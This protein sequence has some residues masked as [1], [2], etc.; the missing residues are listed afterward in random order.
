MLE[1]ITA[2]LILFLLTKPI[3]LIPTI[4]VI[5]L[6]YYLKIRKYNKSSYYKITKVNYFGIKFDKGKYGEYLIY[7]Y[8]MGLEQ[9]GA[10]F[11]FN[12]YVPKND[13]EST[14]ID[15]LMISRKGLFVFESKNYSGWIFGSEFQKYWYQTLPTGRRNRSHKEKFYNPIYQNNTHIKYLNSLI[16]AN[17]PTYSIITFSERCT[18]RNIE[19]KTPNVYVINRYQIRDLITSIYENKPDILTDKEITEIYN[20]LYPCTQVD[21]AIRQKH[22]DNINNKFKNNYVFSNI[23][24]NSNVSISTLIN[25]NEPIIVE[26]EIIEKPQSSENINNKELICPLCGA[27]LELKTARYKT[28]AGQKFYGC[29]NYPKCK[30]IDNSNI[31]NTL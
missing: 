23:L 2:L 8:L 7:K 3:I 6:I 19:V 16:G 20:N 13:E 28:H 17:Y 15:V 18:L 4:T 24:D 1:L 31:S 5:I 27:K 29:S 30:Y 9:Q 10:K 11:L 14:E 21:E 22:I 12:I 25:N 26:P